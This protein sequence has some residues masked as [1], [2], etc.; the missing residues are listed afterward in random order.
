MVGRDDPSGFASEGSLWPSRAAGPPLENVQAL[1][2]VG[3]LL[4]PALDRFE[5]EAPVTADTEARYTALPDHPVDGGSMDL[6]V[7]GQFCDGQNSWH[8]STTVN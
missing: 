6:Q 2:W 8:L 4:L 7:S 1:G 3:I 5:T